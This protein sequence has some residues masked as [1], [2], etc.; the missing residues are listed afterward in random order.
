MKNK[1]FI[2][3]T[4]LA[5][6]AVICGSAGF[7][8][9]SYKDYKNEV[10]TQQQRY[11]LAQ[12]Q[13]E[14][15][16]ED[17]LVETYNL[18]AFRPS[19]YVGKLLT[20]L[21][22]GGVE[23][24]FKTTP[25]EAADGTGLSTAKLGDFIVFT[26]NPGA[27][28]EE[29]IS[30]SAVAT[31]S[32]QA[33]WTIINR[34]LSFTENAVITANKNQH[35]IGETV[36]ISNDDH[37]LSQQF[38]DIDTQSQ[39][40]VGLK[41][42]NTVLPTSSLNATTSEQFV[43]KAVLDATAVQGVATS[44]ETNGGIVEL[45]TL[46]EQSTGFS[47]GANKPTVLQTKNSTS[48]PDIRGTYNVVAESDGFLDRDWI[49]L[50][51][52]TWSFLTA[53]QGVVLTEQGTGVPSLSIGAVQFNS[54]D[55]WN[56]DT[57]GEGIILEANTDGSG[58]FLYFINETLTN[59]TYNASSTMEITDEGSN[60]MLT[61]FNGNGLDWDVK[62]QGDT[63]ANLFYSDAST[64]RVGIGDATPSTKLEVNGT[65]TMTECVGCLSQYER[66]TNTGA[67][68]TGA[69][70]QAT[71]SVDC[72]AGKTVISGGGSNSLT[73]DV[74]IHAN[75]PVDSNTWRVTYEA[76]PGGAAANTITAYAICVNN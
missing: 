49:D 40:I 72:S 43:T 14:Q 63:D 64:D 26:I 61:N 36:I 27:D 35:S 10:K 8:Y 24:T 62:M 16:Y 42:F 6:V 68:P 28:N 74:W 25:D 32:D 51:E 71:V 55:G 75:Y 17:L 48:S 46:A 31:S 65:T 58:I 23:A 41:T 34:G 1:G 29:K 70:T 57:G 38:V 4:T 54:V 3:I 53:D 22:E 67:G 52:D 76:D 30:V 20:R 13:Y 19:N 50:T 66:V 56:S 7:S 39:N 69:N 2:T 60:R 9:Q 18:G 11:E 21:D 47:G 45:G 59:G 5:L 15:R 33:T 44:T 37:Y 73:S 12:E